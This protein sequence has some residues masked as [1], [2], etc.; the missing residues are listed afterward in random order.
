[1][2]RTAL[3]HFSIFAVMVVWDWLAA[4]AIRFTAEQSHAAPLFAMLIAVVWVFAVRLVAHRPGLLVA[5]TVGA[6]VGTELGILWP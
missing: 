3:T 2:L 4:L 5:V 1:M 6:G